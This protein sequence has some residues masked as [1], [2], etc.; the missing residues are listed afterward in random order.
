MKKLIIFDLD[1]TLYN[2]S[3]GSFAKSDLKKYILLNARQ[4][5]KST[6]NKNEEESKKILSEINVKYGENI[7][8]ALEEMFSIN[9]F[10]YFN[11]VWNINPKGIVMPNPTLK[12]LLRNLIKSN[13]KLVVVSDAP[14]IWISNVLSYLNILDIFEKNIF[15]GE[16]DYRKSNGNALTQVLKILNYKPEETLVV[17]DQEKT[18]IIPAKELG[19]KTIYI[20]TVNTSKMADYNIRSINEIKDIL[21]VSY[22]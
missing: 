4:F 11:N 3:K 5:I 14:R 21:S 15:S 13:F 12:P 8:I 17:G 19:A 16:S 6:L 20:N 10:D 7:S 9:R 2:F 1:G 18:D 22:N